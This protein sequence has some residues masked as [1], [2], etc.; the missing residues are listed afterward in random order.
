MLYIYN[1]QTF[2]LSFFVAFCLMRRRREE[3]RGGEKRRKRR[4]RRSYTSVEI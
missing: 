4:R 3:K 2:Y 1:I